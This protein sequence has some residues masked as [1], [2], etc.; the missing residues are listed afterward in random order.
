M[1]T[2]IGFGIV[3]G[4]IIGGLIGIAILLLML[5]VFYCFEMWRIERE[6]QVRMRAINIKYNI[7]FTV[8]KWGKTIYE[9]DKKIKKEA[10]K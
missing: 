6:H 9:E 4:S 3:G 1:I 2:T 8:N 10:S 5:Y 7:P